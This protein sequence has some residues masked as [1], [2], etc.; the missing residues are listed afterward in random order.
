MLFSWVDVLEFNKYDEEGV[1]K[2]ELPGNFRIWC[3]M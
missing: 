1:R 3:E 2:I